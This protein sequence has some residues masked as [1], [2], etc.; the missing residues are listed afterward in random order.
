MTATALLNKIEVYN[1]PLR[2]SALSGCDGGPYP[3]PRT[4]ANERYIALSIAH[5]IYNPVG[6]Y[7]RVGVWKVGNRVEGGGEGW[8]VK[9]ADPK[10]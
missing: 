5:R 7:I 6:V 10:I 4:T 3:S 8:Q 2:S 9:R 1:A